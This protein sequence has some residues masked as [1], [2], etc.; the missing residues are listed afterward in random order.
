MS[1]MNVFIGPYP[2]IKDSKI[3][4]ATVFALVLTI[5]MANKYFVKSHISVTAY[6][7]PAV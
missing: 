4:F 2:K 5:G 3:A 1:D 6:M 7:L